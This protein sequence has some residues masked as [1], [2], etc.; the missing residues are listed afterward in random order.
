M[1][2]ATAAPAAIGSGRLHW[3]AVLYLLTVVLPISM[4]IGSIHL[5]TLRILLLMVTLPMLVNLLR[6]RYGPVLATDWLFLLHAAWLTLALAI[7][8]PDRV[9]QQAPSVGVEFLGGYVLARATIRSAAD[10]VALCRLMVM[11][12]LI[13]LPFALLETQTG[14]PLILQ[15][16]RSLPGITS[17]EITRDDPRLGL[18]RVQTVFAHPIHYGLFCSVAF[19]MAFVALKGLGSDVWRFLSAGGVALAGFTALSSGA[20]LAIVLQVALIGWAWMFRGMERRWWLL[21][22]LFALAYIAVD[23]IS[24]RSAF[25]VFMS[26]ATFSAHNA[27]WRSIIFE[28]GVMNI[29]G[30]AENE[31]PPSILFGIGLKDWVRPYFMYSGSMDNFWLVMGVRYGVPGFAFIALGW[32]WQ[33][34]RLMRVR[35]GPGHP[36]L[37]IRRACVFTLLGLSFTLATVH[38]WGNLFSFTLFVLGATAWLVQPGATDMGAPPPA[39]AG[40]ARPRTSY[41]RFAPRPGRAMTIRARRVS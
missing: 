1:T 6:G 29:F 22:G 13:S 20:L 34:A 23:L 21:V 8:N 36:L 19:S 38:V 10:F 26:H 14:D 28:W 3:L 25:Q 37:F 35:L 18:A 5:T 16:I 12:V 39:P 33:V 32:A 2:A 17:V 24:N 4:N 9:I 15:V 27:Y 31:I 40:P 7:N 30:N 41:T 11:L